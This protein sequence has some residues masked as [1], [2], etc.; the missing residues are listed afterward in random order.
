MLL[1][2]SIINYNPAS[3]AHEQPKKVVE[4]LI[5]CLPHDHE[6]LPDVVAGR[7]VIATTGKKRKKIKPNHNMWAY[8]ALTLLPNRTGISESDYTVTEGSDD[9]GERWAGERLIKVLKE[10]GATDFLV[11]CSRWFGGTLLGPVR[12]QHIETAARQAIT[13]YQVAET[14]EPLYAELATLDSL[15]LDFRRDLAT[16]AP[17]PSPAS[18]SATLA[19]IQPNAGI[20]DYRLIK[21]VRKLENLVK[22]KTRTVQYLGDQVAERDLGGLADGLDDGE[23]VEA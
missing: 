11:V 10:E 13:A 3:Y 14:L 6:R 2:P 18:S 17:S 4:A 1:P 22:A 12:F 16:T 21:D 5:K 7:G 15:I 19:A 9:D 8:R 23:E 20:P